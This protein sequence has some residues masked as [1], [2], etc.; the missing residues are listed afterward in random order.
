MMLN[1]SSLTAGAKI[2]LSCLVVG[3][4]AGSGAYL[5]YHQGQPVAP[6]VLV[7]EKIPAEKQ[8][9]PAPRVSAA[10][11]SIL[12]LVNRDN[13]LQKLTLRQLARIYRGEVTEWPNG[14]AIM[15]INRPIASEVRRQF[16]DMVLNANPVQKFFQ[17]G[18][19]IPFETRRVD[20]EESVARFVAKDRG[21]IGYCFAPCA[22]SSVK[23]IP[24]NKLQS[25][26]GKAVRNLSDRKGSVC[27][28][29][30]DGC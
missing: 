25:W 1:F 7:Q 9:S 10:K 23:A 26:E 28:G 16:Y 14:E 17:T 2:G 3:L 29:S 27:S 12:I 18:S 6:K 21:A 20:S 11:R 5:Y 30:E 4:A 19:P 24:L 22:D 8:A 15:A 13:P